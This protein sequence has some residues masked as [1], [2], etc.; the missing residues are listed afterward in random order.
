[1]QN[2]AIFNNLNPANKSTAWLEIGILMLGS[3]LLGYF[4]RWMSCR[5][6]QGVNMDMDDT[7]E[8]VTT[9]KPVYRS[10]NVNVAPDDLKIVEGIGPKIE[11]LLNDAGIKTFAALADASKS[12]IKKVLDE[13]GPRYQMHDPSTW[14]EQ[15][16]LA[17]DGKM[18]QLEALKDRLSAGKE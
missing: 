12:S 13:A 3:F 17:R 10:S 5:S 15:A 9:A 8:E 14:M 1:M 11:G 7:D 18:K 6:C 2:L 16:S 4:L